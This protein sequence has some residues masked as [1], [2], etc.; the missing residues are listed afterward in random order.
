MK[1]QFML[2]SAVIVALTVMT[3]ASVVSDVQTREFDVED[4]SPHIVSVQDEAEKITS[5][6][7]TRLERQNFRKLVGYT[8]YRSEVLYSN[9]LNCFNVTMTRPGE[10]IDLQCIS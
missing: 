3:V 9:S 7:P 5:S 8:D 1:A 10:R 4:T 2:I 6:T